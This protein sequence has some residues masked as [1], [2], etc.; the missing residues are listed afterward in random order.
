VRVVVEEDHLRVG[1]AARD[2]VEHAKTHRGQTFGEPSRPTLCKYY[3]ATSC[4]Y[5]VQFGQSRP[6]GYLRVQLEQFNWL[7]E[8][9]GFAPDGTIATMPDTDAL[10]AHIETRWSEAVRREVAAAQNVITAPATG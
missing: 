7:T 6:P 9:L 8:S 4:S 3:D 10:R 1:L 5:V 2:L